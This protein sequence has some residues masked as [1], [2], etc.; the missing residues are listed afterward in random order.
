L[1]KSKV[2]RERL[3]SF[4]ASILS[5]PLYEGALLTLFNRRNGESSPLGVVSNE[6]FEQRRNLLLLTARET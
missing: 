6:G 1:L 5:A 2:L 3:S 4:G